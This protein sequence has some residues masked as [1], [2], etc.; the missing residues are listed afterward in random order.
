M[1]EGGDDTH[2]F[3]TGLPILLEG[4][5]PC[6]HALPLFL[7]RLATEVNWEEESSCF[8][9]ICTELGAFYAQLPYDDD[10]EE[11]DASS[12][13]ESNK[14]IGDEADK[15]IRHILYPAISFLLVPHK[16]LAD[17]GSIVKLAMLP[18]LYKIFE[19]C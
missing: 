16:D 13:K 11:E 8:K 6:P 1:K 10:D 18:S 12:S 14:L 15:R 3:L 7:L 9:D 4:H 19:R 17:D 2:L 5:E